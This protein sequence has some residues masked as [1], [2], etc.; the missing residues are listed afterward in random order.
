MNKNYPDIYFTPEYG[1]VYEKWENGVL[2]RFEYHTDKGVVCNQFI[3][4]Q[5]PIKID[6]QQYYD[7]VSPY[8][9][10]GPIVLKCIEGGKEDLIKGYYN[11]FKEYC[12]ENNIVSEFIRFHPILKNHQDFEKVYKVEYIRNTLATNIKDFDDPVQSEFSKSCRK[13]IRQGI[14][15]GL[16]AEIDFEC[17]TIDDF[18][19]IYYSTMDR[20][21]AGKYYYFDRD[22]FYNMIKNFKQNLMIFNVKLEQ[23]TVAAGFYMR[24]EG[25]LHAH[26]SGTLPEYLNISPANIIRHTAVTWGKENGIEYLHHGGGTSNSVEDGLYKFKKGFS[27]N[28][29]FEFHVAKK[30]WNER[31]Y[32]QLVD[33]V[34]QEKELNEQFFPLYR[35]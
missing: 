28:T 8:G 22:Y 24:Y 13:K 29:E 17:N 18:I 16:Y 23:K 14:N 34:S 2:G 21:E 26:L 5:I 11:A 20:N 19:E 3:K 9:Y 33:K 15:K 30:V 32:N 25:L 7:I 10:G 12:K 6:Q 4:R 35:S 27:Q 1:K 31:V